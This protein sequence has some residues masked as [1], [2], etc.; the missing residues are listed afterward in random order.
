MVKSI[1]EFGSYISCALATIGYIAPNFDLPLRESVQNRITRI[2]NRVDESC[3]KSIV[4][5]NDNS[6]LSPEE[7]DGFAIR[8]DWMAVGADMKEAMKNYAEQSS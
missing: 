7:V 1:I 2:R 6:D 4:E 3:G 5:V 8:S